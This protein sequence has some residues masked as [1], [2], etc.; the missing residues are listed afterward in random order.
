MPW[1]AKAAL[2]LIVPRLIKWILSEL[3]DYITDDKV[4]DVCKG[5]KEGRDYSSMEHL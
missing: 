1:I 2:Q 3:E 4:K 5:V